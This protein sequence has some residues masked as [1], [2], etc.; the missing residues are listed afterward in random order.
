MYTI[1]LTLVLY[2]LAPESW[3]DLVPRSLPFGSGSLTTLALTFAI[4]Y[5]L[6]DLTVL[7]F[8]WLGKSLSSRIEKKRI[9]SAE[10]QAKKVF[11]DL[12]EDEVNV[13]MLYLYENFEPI[14]FDNTDM[15]TLTLSKRKVIFQIK[16]S[17]YYE[18]HNC[19]HQIVKDHYMAHGSAYK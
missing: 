3:L 8:S 5:A 15:V 19:F 17:D 18:L 1:L 14:K 9:K 2:L 10:A 11:L 6:V 4:S 13:V 16:Q 12:S 7:A